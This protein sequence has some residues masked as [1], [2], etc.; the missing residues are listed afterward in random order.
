MRVELTKL[1]MFSVDDDSSEPIGGVIVRKGQTE[2]I[3]TYYVVSVVGNPRKYGHYGALEGIWDG[4]PVEALPLS[5]DE[6]VVDADHGDVIWWDL[7]VKGEHPENRR[8]LVVCQADLSIPIRAR[9]NI[10]IN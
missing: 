8:R 1:E 5:E 9:F 4:V 7:R 10:E 3:P 2:L 6:E